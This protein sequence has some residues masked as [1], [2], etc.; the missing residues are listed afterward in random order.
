MN[1]STTK[2][3]HNSLNNSLDNSYKKI[4]LG[5]DHGGFELKEKIKGWLNEWAYEFEDLGASELDPDDDYP[6]YAFAVAKKVASLENSLGILACRSGGGMVIAANKVKGIRAEVAYDI[7]SA[8]HA[9]ENNNV[10]VI[11]I[12]ADWTN[13]NEQKQI[14]RSFLATSFSQSQRHIR[15]IAEISSY[16]N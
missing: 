2:Y 9:K 15:R 1:N 8:I 12:P 5:S 4:F 16:E 11:S 7:R 13:E 10:N 6:K 14:L 3:L